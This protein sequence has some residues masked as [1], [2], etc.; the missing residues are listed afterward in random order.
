MGI[1]AD[2]R[3]V[4]VPLAG[5]DPTLVGEL[6]AVGR[7]QTYPA[8]ALVR[9]G[10]DRAEVHLVL[11]G[12]V[13]LSLGSG[14][15]RVTATV[16]R[17]GEAFNDAHVFSGRPARFEARTLEYTQLL[18]VDG[19]ALVDLVARHRRVALEWLR[20]S[21]ERS[22]ELESRLIELLA[23]DV[24]TRLALLLLDE[25]EHGEVELSQSVLARL[26]GA[27]R[28]SVNRALKAFEAAG[29]IRLGYRRIEVLD[30]RALRATAGLEPVP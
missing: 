13:E 14:A 29:T 5:R 16:V 20:A 28:T 21:A 4:A 8:G 9:G 30:P 26:L 24:D 22:Y 27:H 23:H 17:P 11:C 3:T 12:A 1:Q 19:P 7:T 2:G 15:R 6:L 25:A 18:T 10:P